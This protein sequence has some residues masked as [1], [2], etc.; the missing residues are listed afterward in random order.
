MS[1]ILFG[2]VCTALYKKSIVK[3]H[4]VKFDSGIKHNE[5][6][7]FNLKYLQF[8]NSIK[9]LSDDYLYVYRANDNSTSRT[10][11][12][13]EDKF[14]VANNIISTVFKDDTV[15]VDQMRAR[16]VSIGLWRILKICN[17]NNQDKL[18]NKITAIRN[19]CNNQEVIQ[20]LNYVDVKN[21]NKYKL[22]YFYL[23]KLKRV[24]LTYALTRYV[25]PKLTKILSR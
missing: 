22:I 1:G 14:S 16:N 11:N 24:Y 19:V 4:N 8:C 10:V 13:N 2:S 15:M 6:G 18:I 9:M 21:L 17:K 3:T 23:L 5:D 7:L 25:Y 20:G 12:L